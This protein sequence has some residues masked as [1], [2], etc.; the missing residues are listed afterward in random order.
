MVEQVI[1]NQN[2]QC[3]N[4]FSVSYLDSY[5]ELKHLVVY[6]LLNE[7]AIHKKLVNLNLHWLGFSLSFLGKR[8]VSQGIMFLFNVPVSL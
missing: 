2:P 7:G 3:L 4:F 8:S 1:L 6:D 5:V